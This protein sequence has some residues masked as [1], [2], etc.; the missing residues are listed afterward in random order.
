MPTPPEG[1]F[2]RVTYRNDLFGRVDVVELRK[3]VNKLTSHKVYSCD[4]D[5]YLGPESIKHAAERVLGEYEYDWG[6]QEARNRFYGDY[7][8][9]KLGS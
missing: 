8:P 3:F 5:G 1:H 6:V 4:V 9:A 7:P 2:W